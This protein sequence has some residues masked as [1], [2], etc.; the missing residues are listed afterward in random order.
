MGS[1]AA[2]SGGS[3]TTSAEGSEDKHI[4]EKGKLFLRLVLLRS[5]FVSLV[6]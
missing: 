1:F 2:N 5:F 6:L 4:E 3:A